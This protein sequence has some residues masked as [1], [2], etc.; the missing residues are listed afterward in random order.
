MIEAIY[1][2]GHLCNVTANQKILTYIIAKKLLLN[3]EFNSDPSGLTEL[4]ASL[5]DHVT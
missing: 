2:V 1:F 3:P 4:L 5:A